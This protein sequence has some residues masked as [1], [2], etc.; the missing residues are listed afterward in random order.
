MKTRSVHVVGCV[1]QMGCQLGSKVGYAVRFDQKADVGGV[2]S[3]IKFVTDG[4]LL[5]EV[6][7]RGQTWTLL[8]R[9]VSLIDVGAWGCA[10][11]YKQTLFDPLLSSYSVVMLD[12]AHERNM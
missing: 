8:P 2:K 10:F 5:R 6:R 3:S 1:A 7:T 11:S 9:L 4:L 12:E